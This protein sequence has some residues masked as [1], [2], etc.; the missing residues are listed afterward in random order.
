MYCNVLNLFSGRNRPSHPVVYTNRGT[1][2]ASC[3]S[4][5]CAK[6]GTSHYHSSYENNEGKTIFHKVSDSTQYFQPTA[7]TVFEVELLK[8]LTMQLAFSA[9]TFES[10]TSVYN[11]VH[12]DEDRIRLQEF[13]ANLRRSNLAGR[14][15]GNDWKLNVTRFD[16][17]W[18]T[19]K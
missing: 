11:A 17:G 7:H 19:Y 15:D 8:H 16:D 14:I 13:T 5:K 4:G 9:C 18:F 3:F 10:Q 6:C 1:F 12:C 2:I